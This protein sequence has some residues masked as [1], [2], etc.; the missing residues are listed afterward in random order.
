MAYELMYVSQRKYQCLQD[1]QRIELKYWVAQVLGI[2]TRALKQKQR[3]F[4]DWWF[5]ELGLFL[6]IIPEP[7]DIFMNMTII[8]WYRNVWKSAMMRPC[9]FFYFFFMF[10]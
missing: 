8:P 2:S 9:F 3:F 7:S 1:S 5:S 6:N 4:S 10:T